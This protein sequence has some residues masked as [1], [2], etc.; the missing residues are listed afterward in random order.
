VS[1]QVVTSGMERRPVLLGFA[2]LAIGAVLGIM[3]CSNED[4]I[5]SSSTST[6][7]SVARLGETT[8][9]TGRKL[10]FT[11]NASGN[12]IIMA[13]SGTGPVVELTPNSYDNMNPEPSSDGRSLVYYCDQND[14]T[15][16]YLR[17]YD[18]ATR[19]D[20]RISPS[21]GHYY[22]DP[23]F[24]PDGRVV[25]KR[26]QPDGTLGDI[27]I[28]N[29]D[30]SAMRMLTDIAP[31]GNVE[32]WKPAPID[33]RSVVITMRLQPN[34]PTKQ[35]ANNSD[36][37][38]I[39]DTESGGITQLTQNDGR[40]HWY[41]TVRPGGD[42]VLFIS[43]DEP[44]T[45]SPTRLYTVSLSA[46]TSSASP[47]PITPYSLTGDFADPFWTAEGNIVCTYDPHR[48]GNLAVC[49]MDSSGDNVGLYELGDVGSC[50]GPVMTESV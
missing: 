9:S 18:L 23:A 15:P 13:K 48:L 34:A 39:L 49:G 7:R 22:Y 10:I 26:A 17:R 43:S 1:E 14:G 21:D 37:L 19:Q 35:A 27:G 6:A 38:A 12:Y 8:I 11:A 32:L 36:V 16:T 44:T 41:P 46:K 2:G 50:L 42:S 25:F 4:S 30:G 29:A 45:S 33:N 28:M 47:T 3:G 5:E 40:P 31:S 24:M 20:V